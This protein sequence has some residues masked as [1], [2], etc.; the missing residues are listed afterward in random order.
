MT[1]A[2]LDEALYLTK[3]MIQ[4]EGLEKVYEVKLTLADD[5]LEELKARKIFADTLPKEGYVSLYKNTPFERGEKTSVV[6]VEKKPKYRPF[7][8]IDELIATWQKMM[9]Y[10]AKE[11]T[12]PLIW[13]RSNDGTTVCISSFGGKHTVGLSWF[14][15][16]AKD[17]R[18]M[19]NNFTFLDGSPFGVSE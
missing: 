9:G 7:K 8:D 15:T 14:N 2:E 18:E 6:I 5:V 3:G 10:K 13:V 4:R 1:V 16:E 17:I 11:N 12:M 19:F